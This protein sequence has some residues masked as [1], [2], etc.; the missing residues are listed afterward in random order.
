MLR[1]PLFLLKAKIVLHRLRYTEC[2]SPVH[3]VWHVDYVD[4]RLSG[5]A[6]VGGCIRRGFDIEPN[7]P[8]V[9]AISASHFETNILASLEIK[10]NFCQIRLLM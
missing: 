10:I 9:L 7:L 3:V 4:V 1:C 8:S 5:G 2:M 6:D